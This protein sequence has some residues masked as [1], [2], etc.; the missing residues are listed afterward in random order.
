MI[1]WCMRA[2]NSAGATATGKIATPKTHSWHQTGLK[3]IKQKDVQHVQVGPVPAQDKLCSDTTKGKP[4]GLFYQNHTDVGWP[5]DQDG[6]IKSPPPKKNKSRCVDTLLYG[7]SGNMWFGYTKGWNYAVLGGLS[8][9]KTLFVWFNDMLIL[10]W[11]WSSACM[12]SGVLPTV[13]YSWLKAK[14][15][16]C[17]SLSIGFRKNLKNTFFSCIWSHWLLQM[18]V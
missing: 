3:S 15:D 17:L 14:V 4:F 16:K 12:H 6:G 13:D 2:A 9:A 18:D 10:Q 7:V 11:R 8:N 1:P 5:R